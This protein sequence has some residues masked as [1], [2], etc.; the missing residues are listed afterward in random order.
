M[1]LPTAFANF[2]I[3]LHKSCTFFNLVNCFS[4]TIFVAGL[5]TML[6]VHHIPICF[7]SSYLMFFNF[8]LE[9][10]VFVLFY[11][12]NN[13]LYSLL[14]ILLFFEASINMSLETFDCCMHDLSFL[15]HLYCHLS[16]NWLSLINSF[17]RFI[18]EIDT[19]LK[20]HYFL[21]EQFFKYH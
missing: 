19:P 5:L 12:R 14:Y 7:F 16:T 13:F 21:T 4:G 6:T 11:H 2:A 8:Y 17:D 10:N 1:G 15:H 3:A 18:N 20:E 9:I